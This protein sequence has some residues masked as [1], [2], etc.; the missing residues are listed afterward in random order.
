MNN[1]YQQQPQPQQQPQQQYYAPPPKP[2]VDPAVA[3]KQKTDALNEL[4]DKVTAFMNTNPILAPLSRISD[5]IAYAALGVMA[6]FSILCMCLGHRTVIFALISLITGFLA[7]SKK[8]VLP[9]ALSLSVNTVL[10]FVDFIMTIV[11]FAQYGRFGVS[12]GTVISFIFLIVEMA[13]LGFL[14]YI[15]WTYFVAGLPAK[16]YAPQQPTYPQQ[17]VQPAQ[18]VQ[19][20]QPAQPAQPVQPVQPAQPAQPV[21]PVQPAQPVQPVQPVQQAQPVQPAQSAGKVCPKCGQQNV[22]GAAFCKSCGEKL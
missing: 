20:V 15:A 22:E 7:L 16:T 13:V 21:Q 14:A 8:N 12:G 1:Q 2:Y 10:Y 6:F 17:P 19:P 3:K 9:L 5:F 18:P 4:G 11:Y